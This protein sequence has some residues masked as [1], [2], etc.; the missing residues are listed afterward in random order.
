MKNRNGVIKRDH[1]RMGACAHMRARVCVCHNEQKEPDKW[2]ARQAIPA[3]LPVSISKNNVLKIATSVRG[4]N[5]C[6]CVCMSQ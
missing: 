5:V 6:V 4:L 2:Q 3:I 1:M